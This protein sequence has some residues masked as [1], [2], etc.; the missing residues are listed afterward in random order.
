[1]A[2]QRLAPAGTRDFFPEDVKLRERAFRAIRETFERYGF[3]PL[4]TPAYER[5]ELLAGK[6]GE[7]GEKLIFKILKRGVHAASGEADLALRYDFTVPLARVVAQHRDRIGPVFKR[8]QIG[9]VWRADRPGKARY[10]EFFQCDVDTVG[11]ASPL[12]DAEVLLALTEALGA[13]GL[14]DFTV[15][16]NS[17]KV[18]QGLLRAYA[19][20]AEHA[21]G[22]LVALDKLDKIG[23]D[24]VA[25]ELAERGAPAAAVAEMMKDVRAASPIERVRERLAGPGVGAEGLAEVDELTALVSPLLRHGK[26]AQ[27]PFLVRGLD[28]Y[29]GP[30]FEVFSGDLSSSIA[31]GGRYD[32]LI[33]A[34]SGGKSLPA[35]GG[36]LGIERIL[37]LLEGRAEKEDCTATALVAVWNE[38]MREDA[39]RLATELR[40]CGVSTDVYLGSGGVKKQ[41]RQASTAGIPLCVLCGPDEKAR[42]EV[43]IRDMRAGTQRSEPAAGFAERLAAELRAAEERGSGEA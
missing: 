20:P 5:V 34:L 15:R 14:A 26:L 41:L 37:L 31:S 33:G 23:A 39:L 1:M 9:P 19:L 13:L 16:L 10:R 7:E 17:R 11:S 6:Y 3:W 38:E 25:E 30:V 2:T 27:D 29:T 22:A 8:Y 4:E 36:S 42:G 35:C 21:S 32:E 18:L 12:A 24:A 43:V 28:Y 40:R